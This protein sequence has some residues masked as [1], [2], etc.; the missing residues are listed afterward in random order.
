MYETKSEHRMLPVFAALFF[1]NV[2]W[3]AA[4]GI[5]NMGCRNMS[6]SP[7][8]LNWMELVSSEIHCLLFAIYR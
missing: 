4:E 7:Y 6:C 8:W 5:G 1:V 3:L 2:L